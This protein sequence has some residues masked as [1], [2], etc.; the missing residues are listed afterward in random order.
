TAKV[1]RTVW[2][3]WSTSG[4]LVE[5]AGCARR[6]G[7]LGATGRSFFL[8]RPR[9]GSTCRGVAG[10]ASY[11]RV[12]CL[13]QRASSAARCPGD[14]ERAFGLVARVLQ[15]AQCLRVGDRVDRD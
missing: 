6:F 8:L 1:S 13:D 9:F 12:L 15:L 14:G 5:L 3:E 7:S 4:A 2:V 11:R 10:S